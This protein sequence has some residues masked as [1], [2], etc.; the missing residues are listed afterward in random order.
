MVVLNRGILPLQSTLTPLDSCHNSRESCLNKSREQ[1]IVN[2]FLSHSWNDGVRQRTSPA[3]TQCCRDPTKHCSEFDQLLVRLGSISFRFRNLH[4][5][6]TRVH[7]ECER[8]QSS[9]WVRL[10]FQRIWVLFHAPSTN[11]SNFQRHT[12]F[13]EQITTS[14]VQSCLDRLEHSTLCYARDTL[15]RI[16]IL[17]GDMVLTLTS[18]RKLS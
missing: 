1:Q 3:S 10:L 14:R 16:L 5:Q 8:K 12:R 18:F 15:S 17:Q 13:Q 4:L 7:L 9:G 2:W 11:C 6:R